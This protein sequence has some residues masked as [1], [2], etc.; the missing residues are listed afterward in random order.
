MKYLPFI[1]CLKVLSVSVVFVGS[2][3]DRPQEN[4]P[5]GSSNSPSRLIP[6]EGQDNFRDMGGYRTADG[7]TVKGRQVFRSGELPKLADDDVAALDELGVKTVVDFLTGEKIA[8]RG[9]DRLP[10][11]VRKAPLSMDADIRDGTQRK[12]NSSASRGAA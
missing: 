4:S 1:T 8:S 3:C 6:L 2:G 12:G 7:R 5:K 11:G 10:D 9:E